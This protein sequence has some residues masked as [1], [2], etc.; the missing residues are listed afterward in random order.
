M[1]PFLDGQFPGRIGSGA[2]G[3][4]GLWMVEGVLYSCFF[5]RSGNLW[6]RG[7]YMIILR[8]LSKGLERNYAYIWRMVSL[9]LR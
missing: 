2:G 5:Y 6:L 9:S 4:G 1:A 3:E 7:C 8:C